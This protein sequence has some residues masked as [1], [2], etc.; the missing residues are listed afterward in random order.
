MTSAT[1]PQIPVQL[2]RGTGPAAGGGRR[3]RLSVNITPLERLWRVV[4]GAAGA[5]AGAL[6][7]L[8]WPGS[9][10][11]A[12]LELL[13]VAAGLDLVVTGVLG[14]CPLYQRLGYVP[15]SLRRPT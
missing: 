12:F 9:L 2:D 10:L 13:L 3:R 15:R 7:L 5:C 14:H 8:A 11:V 1:H 6:L 4:I